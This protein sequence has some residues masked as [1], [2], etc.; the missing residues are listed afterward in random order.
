[1]STFLASVAAAI[2]KGFPPDV[3]TATV[4]MDPSNG[5]TKVSGEG[6]NL[7]SGESTGPAEVSLTGDEVAAELDMEPN[8]E[9]P[10]AAKS[11][12]PSEGAPAAPKDA[13]Q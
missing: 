4:T 3:T 2:A 7:E 11:S 9:T 6:I 12:K 10:D 1:M 13:P 5:T 8:G